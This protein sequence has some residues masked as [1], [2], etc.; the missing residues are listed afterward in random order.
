MSMR[1]TRDEVATKATV[2]SDQDNAVSVVV[3]RGFH[4]PPAIYGLTV[5]AYLGFLGIM[6]LAFGTAHLA[7]PMV[8]FAVSIIGGFIIPY[9]W[10]TMKP[11]SGQRAIDMGR[12]K[13]KGVQTLTGPLT[14]G[15]ASAQVLTLPI[16]I[17]CWGL[18]VLVISSFVSG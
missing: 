13:G 2:H 16:L 1:M 12:F 17:F 5:G 6:T 11:D 3:D 9:I 8:I 4:L 10:A 18:A 7:I 15:E 14:A